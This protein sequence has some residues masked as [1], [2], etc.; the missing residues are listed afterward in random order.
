M[1]GVTTIRSANGPVPGRLTDAAI[2][3]EVGGGNIARDDTIANRVAE[4]ASK[5][6]RIDQGR[7]RKIGEIE[8]RVGAFRR[9]PNPCRTSSRYRSGV[10]RYRG[11]RIEINVEIHSS[12]HPVR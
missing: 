9:L 5:T 1:R 2:A 3:E 6:L 8:V 10:L 12:C 11:T 7:D 4:R